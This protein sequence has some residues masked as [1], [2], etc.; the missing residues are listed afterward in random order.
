MFKL[1]RVKK[2]SIG[3]AAAVAVVAI[4]AL[5]LALMRPALFS[6][7]ERTITSD[8]VGAQFNDIAELATEEYVFSEVGKFDDEG[9]RVLDVEVPF[10]GK[11]FLVS[12][13]GRV[14]AGIKDG[15]QIDAEFDDMSKKLVVSLPNVEVLTSHVDSQSAEVWDQS[16]NPLNQVKVSDVTEFIASRESLAKDKAIEHG[17]LD[18]AREQ[19]E[20]LVRAQAEALLAGTSK[21]SYEIE[22]RWK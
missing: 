10:T 4:L 9:L 13:D 19:A 2:R 1:S 18:R 15:S 7:G 6:A 11:N 21:E 14:T 8:M 22:V 16:M 12:Y 20:R 5:V 3:C 17:L